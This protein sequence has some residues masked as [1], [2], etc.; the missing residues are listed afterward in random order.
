M[1]A[2][3]IKAIEIRVDLSKQLF[4]AALTL[5][6]FQ[7]ALL[8]FVLEKKEGQWYFYLAALL[9]FIFLIL[10]II[11]SGIGIDNEAAKLELKK[12]KNKA[13]DW[14]VLTVLLG[15]V[16]FVGS[17]GVSLFLPDKFEKKSNKSR[18]CEIE[19]ISAASDTSANEKTRGLPLDTIKNLD[20]LPINGKAVYKSRS[21][22][23]RIINHK[24]APNDEKEETSFITPGNH[25]NYAE[26]SFSLGFPD[27]RRDNANCDAVGCPDHC[28]FDGVKR[29]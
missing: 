8:L 4:G 2:E 16:L 27:P 13:F 19:K 5:M 15:I 11:F 28:N 9:A 12:I 10:S 21:G 25:K 22:K 3:E 18:C 17:V 20:E 26:A 14:Q 23:K 1:T 7:S 24:P 29:K 6:G